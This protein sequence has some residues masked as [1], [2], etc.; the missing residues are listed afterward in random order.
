MDIL[1]LQNGTYRAQSM[2]FIHEFH[3]G[4]SDRLFVDTLL[5]FLSES[6]FTVSLLHLKV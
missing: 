6:S 1:I 3:F 5:S 4:F 2:C